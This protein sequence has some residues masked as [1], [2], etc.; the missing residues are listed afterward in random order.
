[1]ASTTV[2]KIVRDGTV[3]AGGACGNTAREDGGPVSSM[4]VP[5]M[6]VG[7]VHVR[8]AKSHVGVPVRVWFAARYPR[9]VGVLVVLVVPVEVFV[10]HWLMDMFVL[11]VLAHVEP[12]AEAHEGAADHHTSGQRLS[13]R[14]KRCDGSEERSRREV[15]AGPGG[16]E[17]AERAHEEDET[18]SVAKEANRRGG[19]DRSEL[20]HPRTARHRDRQVNGSGGPTLERC[21]EH[22]IAGR[23]L[24]RQVVVHRPRQARSAH[25]HRTPLESE[26]LPRLP[27]EHESSSG[28]QCHPG[29]DPGVE[30]FAERELREQRRQEALEAQK[31]RR[32]DHGPACEAEHEE[33]G[34]GAA[35]TD[36]R[37]R[38]PR[39]IG[40]AQ[41]RFPRRATKPALSEPQATESNA[42]P[43]IQKPRRQPGVARREQ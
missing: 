24:A 43:Q 6:K 13:Q 21:D 9:L 40:T 28:D 8:V 37:S 17:V 36:D 19:D 25:E 31:K 18:D 42:R 38:E 30:V 16:A 27:R 5:M 1:M 12:H 23:D 41:R 4:S 14:C 29:G 11:V 10:L 35:A 15:R 39:K 3:M 7:V 34:T 2:A 22:G 20:W 26:A 32:L 33:D